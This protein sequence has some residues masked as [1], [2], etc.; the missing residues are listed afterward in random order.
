MRR[1]LGSIVLG[2]VLLVPG[3]A[4][5]LKVGDTAP[6][7]TLPSTTGKEISL[8]DYKGKKSVLLAFYAFDFSPT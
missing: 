1:W 2:A 8:A 6:N 7:F 3:Y 4:H 5:A